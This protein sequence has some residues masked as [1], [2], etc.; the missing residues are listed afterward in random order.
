MYPRNKP[1]KHFQGRIEPFRIIGNVYFVGTYDASSHLIDTGDG[2]VLLDT[3]Y[4]DTLHLLIQ[5]IWEL[6]FQPKDIRYIVHTHFHGDHTE[7]TQALAYLSGAKT[8]IGE[9]DKAPLLQ[10]GYF[11]PDI[12]VADGD[13]LTLGNTTIRFLHTPGHTIGTVSLFFDTVD[14]GIT[15]RVGMFGGAGANTLVDTHPT[16]YAGCREDYLASIDRLLKEEVDV[17]IGNHCWNNDTTGRAERLKA[18][19]P[20]AFVD[21]EEWARFLNFCKARCEALD[22]L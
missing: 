4:A 10:K 13:T 20:H 6:G 19:N 18:G 7:G 9:H 17:F 8:V 21:K 5:S 22:P 2:L 1:D 11:I 3:G 16:H 15:Y 12:T 14:D